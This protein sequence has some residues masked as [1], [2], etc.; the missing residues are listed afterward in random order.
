VEAEG[1]GIVNSIHDD[2]YELP[3]QRVNPNRSEQLKKNDGIA[4]SDD[5]NPIDKTK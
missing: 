2:Q 4:T 5:T 1:V 3:L